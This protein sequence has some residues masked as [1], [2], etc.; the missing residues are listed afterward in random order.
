ME[1][2]EQLNGNSRNIP[3]EQFICDVCTEKDTQF[4]KII[5][6]ILKT[7]QIKYIFREGWFTLRNIKTKSMS[8]E[9]TNTV[10]AILMAEQII[11]YIY[12]FIYIPIDQNKIVNMF[13][14]VQF[15]FSIKNNETYKKNLYDLLISLENETYISMKVGNLHK[16]HS[17]FLFK[18]MRDDSKLINHE[19]LIS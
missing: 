2:N 7:I 12:Y 3:F 9:D 18:K 10:S 4:A 6:Y 5:E 11:M 19:K 16:S 17:K 15:T 13:E 8:I 1:N 14:N